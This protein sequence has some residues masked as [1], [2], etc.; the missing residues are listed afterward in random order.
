MVWQRVGEPRDSEE[1]EPSGGAD[2]VGGVDVRL[3]AAAAA[4]TSNRARQK[5][6]T[7]RESEGD[8]ATER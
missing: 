3:R 4:S 1:K 2:G 5:L 6:E 8:G 7:L